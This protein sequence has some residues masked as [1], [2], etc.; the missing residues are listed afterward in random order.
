MPCVVLWALVA[1][2]LVGNNALLVRYCS[3]PTLPD[4]VPANA[5]EMPLLPP[6]CDGRDVREPAD[7]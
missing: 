2:V 5:P 6:V 4:D 3:E 1:V 7:D